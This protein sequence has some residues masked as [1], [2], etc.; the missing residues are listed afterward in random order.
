M[1]AEYQRRP[2]RHFGKI[3]DEY[4]AFCPQVLDHVSV[5]HDLV[6]HVDGCAVQCQRMLDDSNGSFDA[7][8]ES[9]RLR[10]HYFRFLIHLALHPAT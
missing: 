10:Q 9:P 5:V 3:L 6:A 1:G 7:G 8:A 4:R 2:D